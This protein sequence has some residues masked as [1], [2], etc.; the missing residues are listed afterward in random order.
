MY[1]AVDLLLM[2][3]AAATAT[4]KK[5]LIGVE[6]YDFNALKNVEPI[7]SFHP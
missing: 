3:I 4:S 7:L 1:V 2:C 5:A 6:T